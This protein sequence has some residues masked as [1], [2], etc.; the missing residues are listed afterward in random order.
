MANKVVSF[1]REIQLEMSKVAWSTRNELI[2]STIVVLISLGILSLF[3]GICDI[4]LS[5]VV[6]IVMATL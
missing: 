5:R 1:V 2:G 4:V 6:T 3:I